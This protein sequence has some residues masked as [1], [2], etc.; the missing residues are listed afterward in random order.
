MIIKFSPNNLIVEKLNTSYPDN[1][2]ILSEYKLP[3]NKIKTFKIKIL[4]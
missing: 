3:M 1:M 4:K 2:F